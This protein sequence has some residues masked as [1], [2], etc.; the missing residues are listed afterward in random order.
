[1]GG[2]R[3]AGRVRLT[4]ETFERFLAALGEA[5]GERYEALRRRLLIYFAANRCGVA[6]EAADETMDRVARRMAEGVEVGSVES[7]V[8]GVARNVVREGWRRPKAAEVDWNR[9]PAAAPEAAHP[10]AECLEECLGQ[11]APASRR[12]VERFYSGDG[13][14]KIRARAALAAELGIDGNALRV[15]MHR[16]R[17][18]LERCVRECLSGNEMRREVIE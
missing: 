1:L 16:V 11:M 9:I 12:W 3:D 4:P 14:A 18:K 2:I 15:R 17:G 8:L 5:P 7:F 13:G 10:A 6:E